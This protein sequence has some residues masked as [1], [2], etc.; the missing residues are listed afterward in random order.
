MTG[1]PRWRRRAITSS[2][3]DPMRQL[4][5]ILTRESEPFVAEIISRQRAEPDCEVAVVDLTQPEPDYPALLAKIFE[6]D[7]IQVW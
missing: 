7:S 1:S 4:L 5:H 3:F 2:G 6:A